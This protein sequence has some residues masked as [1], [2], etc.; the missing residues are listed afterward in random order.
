[1][2]QSIFIADPFISSIFIAA[3]RLS[4]LSVFVF[5]SSSLANIPPRSQQ[6]QCGTLQ[7][8]PVA[9]QMVSINCSSATP[10]ARF[11]LLHQS[12]FYN[13]LAICEVEVYAR[14]GW[15][16]SLLNLT[17]TWHSFVQREFWFW[18]L[19]STILVKLFWRCLVL[20]YLWRRLTY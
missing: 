8:R 9:G 16:E 12:T 2:E 17:I 19:L 1:M 14:R 13:F 3:L 10:A 20:S 5:N 11:V 4:D 15:L 7:G 6:K 18:E